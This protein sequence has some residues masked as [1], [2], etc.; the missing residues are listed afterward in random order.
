M[1]THHPDFDENKVAEAQNDPGNKI[2]GAQVGDPYSTDNEGRK[3]NHQESRQISAVK[4]ALQL[5]L[6]G[7]ILA[8]C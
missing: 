1:R 7:A 8:G 3:G 6:H 4:V 5:V 2:P